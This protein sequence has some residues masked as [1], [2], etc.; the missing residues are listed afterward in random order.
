LSGTAAASVFEEAKDKFKSAKE[1]F[2]THIRVPSINTAQ[3]EGGLSTTVEGMAITDT[4]LSEKHPSPRS[5]RHNSHSSSNSSKHEP[6]VLHGW[7]LTKAVGFREVCQAIR[8]SAFLTTDLPLIVSLE[9]HADM[10]Q[11]E[12]MVEIMKEEWEGLLIDEAHP[13]CD[14]KE[15]LPRLEELRNK[16]LVKVKKAT[17]TGADLSTTPSSNTLSPTP[18]HDPESGQSGSEDDRASKSKQKKKA[19]ICEALGKLGIYTHSE[20]FRGFDKEEA[21]YPPHVFSIEESRIME[22]HTKQQADLFKHN[23]KYFMRA[24]PAGIR[25]DSSN[26]DPSIFWRKGV[27][28]VALNWQSWDEGMMINEGMFAGEHGWV[29]KPPAYRTPDPSVV[30][31]L[32]IRRMTLDFKITI[33]AG[34]HIPLP[35]DEDDER[36]FHPYVKCELHVDKH[37]DHTASASDMNGRTKEGR[38][39]KETPHSKG[40]H[41]DFGIKGVTLSFIGIPNVVEELSFLRYVKISAFDLYSPPQNMFLLRRRVGAMNWLQKTSDHHALPPSMII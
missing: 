19:K 40:D 39:K 20:S 31:A 2:S 12:V 33:F 22:L 24:Y 16:I 21:S 28:M 7:T 38:Y 6:L 11:Q 34:Q 9:V 15:R 13:T 14:P 5:S 29:L 37:D 8:E 18:T 1:M 17:L 10:D 3:N 23:L 32:E 30:T 25:I 27:Q 36:S 26:P 4:P 41:P 35:P